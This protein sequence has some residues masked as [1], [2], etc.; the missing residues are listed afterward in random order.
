MAEGGLA[1]VTNLDRI[2]A[3]VEAEME[4][5]VLAARAAPQPEVSTLTTDV[6]VS[7]EGRL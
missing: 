4:A 7:Y 5:A 6:Y 1:E 3:E 2:D